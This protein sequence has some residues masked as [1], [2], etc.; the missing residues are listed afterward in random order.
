MISSTPPT[1]GMETFKDCTSLTTVYVPKGAKEA[2]NIVPWNYY[3]IVEFDGTGIAAPTIK[4]RL[5]NAPVY[6]L[7]GRRTSDTAVPG[8]YIKKRKKVL[9]R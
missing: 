5:A 2:Y 3:K 8:L 6:D 9:V 4:Y 7:S 1:T